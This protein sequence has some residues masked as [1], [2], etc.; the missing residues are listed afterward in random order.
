MTQTLFVPD[1]QSASAVQEVDSWA[2]E[3]LMTA[4]KRR[5][6]KESDNAVEICIVVVSL[7]REA[8]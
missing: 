8:E 1:G 3:V 7:F 4:K 6:V 2:R 5:S